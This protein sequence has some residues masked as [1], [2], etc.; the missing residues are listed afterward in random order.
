[1]KDTINFEKKVVIHHKKVQKDVS[2]CLRGT[3]LNKFQ[4]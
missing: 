3:K 2:S 1:M 4:K